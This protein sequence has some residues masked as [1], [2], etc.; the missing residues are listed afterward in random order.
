MDQSLVLLMSVLTVLND[1]NGIKGLDFSA[2]LVICL[3]RR[4][5]KSFL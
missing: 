2:G 3:S 4:Q 5:A 1:D